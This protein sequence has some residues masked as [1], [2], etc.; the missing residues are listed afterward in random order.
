[1]KRC[2]QRL[3]ELIKEV[4]IPDIEDHIDDIFE[5]IASS[6]NA[7]DEEKAQLEEMHEM[8]DEFTEILKDIENKELDKDECAELF[9]EIKEMIDEN[10]ENEED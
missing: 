6:K 1:M 4:V 10:Q 5:A 7:S 2:E 8:K 9:A 3:E